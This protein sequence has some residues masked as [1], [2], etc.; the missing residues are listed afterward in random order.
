MLRD[1][2]ATLARIREVRDALPD[3]K[4]VLL[5]ARMEPAWLT[6]AAAAGA[7]AA[8]AKTFR[9]EGSARWCA[10]SR[11]AMCS[12]PSTRRAAPLRRSRQRSRRCPRS[13]SASSRS[14]A[15]SPPALPTAASQHSC[16]SRSRR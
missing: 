8:I 1:R 11:P 16:G 13:P 10:R 9:L 5:P 2:D 6:E 7:D 14:C 4:I 3:A 15:S 12:T